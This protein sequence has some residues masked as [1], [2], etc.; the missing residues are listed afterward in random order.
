MSRI[1]PA[2]WPRLEVALDELL[3]LAPAERASALARL[4]RGEPAL[5]AALEALLAADARDL[6]LLET[7]ADAIARALIRAAQADEEGAEAPALPRVDRYRLLRL[8]GRGGMGQVYLAEREDGDYGRPI[9]LK[10]LKRGMDSEE[11]R[12]RFQQER[13]ILARL[14]HPSI[15][16]LLDGGLSADGRPFFA[17]EFIEGEPITVHADAA[18][19]GLRERLALF[20]AV[21]AAVG[22]AQQHLVVHRDLK[23]SNILVTP[24]GQVKLLDFGIA[25][26]LAEAEGQGGEALTR[27]GL[28]LMTPEY[29]A[30]EQLRGE[31]VTTATD[32]YALGLVLYEL[33]AGRPALD[34][35]A[36][37]LLAGLGAREAR[38]LAQALGRGP[39]LTDPQV[40]AAATA[41]RLSPRALRRQLGGEL[42]TLV[43]TA[44]RPEP[45]RRYASAE[46]LLEDLRR[47]RA[48][49]P[50]A[51]RPPAIRYRLRKYLRRHRLA[52]GAS[53]AA[54][55]ALSVGLAG[56]AW[57][58]GIARREAARAR[59]VTEFVTGLFGGAHP[60]ATGGSEPQVRD[61]LAQ[62]AARV[63]SE[64]G[65]EPALQ[66]DLLDVI[67]GIHVSLGD[68][69]G[70][71]PL[72]RRALELRE[73]LLPPAH[74]QRRHALRVLGSAELQA[75]HL[76]VADSLLGEALRLFERRPTAAGPELAM[77]LSDRA[78]LEKRRGR[79]EV[80]ER[81]TRRVL[82][83][84][85]A[86][87]GPDHAEV[88]T[89]LNNLGTLL[90]EL[91]RHEEAVAL[92]REALDIRRRRLA[93]AH[94]LIPYSLHNLAFSLERLGRTAEADSIFQESID[95]RRQLYPR[96]HPDLAV[97]LRERGS[98]QVRL[99][100]D[101]LAERLLGEALA[102]CRA[103]LGEQ[104]TE[105]ATARNALAL[106]AYRQ[107][108]YAAAAVGFAEAF[109]V[110]AA[111]L[112]PGHATLI[113]V[114]EN[115]VGTLQAAGD[116]LAATAAAARLDSLRG[117]PAAEL[118]RR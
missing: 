37:G 111:I 99:G 86:H 57:Q 85:R 80:S 11:I 14:E 118:D 48:G 43:D 117:P 12:R 104:H 53:A 113:T 15:A 47:L 94:S 83:L 26:L 78:I 84:D 44:L 7:G 77:L 39:R 69:T 93:P 76:E 32:V 4:R 74:P 66:A 49:R 96:G 64:L 90:A 79:L 56:T 75:D 41:R 2:L 115:L 81:L 1:D 27:T 97:T 68:Y 70:A 98:L 50:L 92:H 16:R 9:A 105:T 25:K 116:S 18:R 91:G 63:D 3:E 58:A 88:A 10:I 106:A 59:A 114:G 95:R 102:M 101:A 23:P 51:A 6:G 73:A 54:V 71:I 52:M 38:P 33:L 103:L 8:L 42:A 34:G 29:A 5:H 61:L 45:E 13:A 24:A 35:S 36:R 72:L 110:L 100:N 46:A 67:G 21:C 62:G 60:D 55:L 28:F 112:P 89:D 22:Y 65:H 40:R 82:D 108:N 31:P 87:Y 107:G 20:E 109:T 17:M 30:P 19:L